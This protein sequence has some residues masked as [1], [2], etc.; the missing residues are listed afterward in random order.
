MT[1]LLELAMQSA[2]QLP[3]DR[4][5][6][7]ARELLRLLEGEQTPEPTD[8]AHVEAIRSGLA[9]IRRG[10]FATDEEIEAVYRSFDE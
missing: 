7:L 3:E 10:E 6:Y 9:Q 1:E 2:S 5:D 8:P 4:Q